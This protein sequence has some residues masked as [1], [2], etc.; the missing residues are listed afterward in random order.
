MAVIT[1]L[2]KLRCK[3]AVK[4]TSDNLDGE[5][6]FQKNKIANL[7]NVNTTNKYETLS[8]VLV[9]DRSVPQLTK[10]ISK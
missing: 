8:E 7:I 5:F 1:F 9:H 6:S 3:K 10:T 4:R 2:L